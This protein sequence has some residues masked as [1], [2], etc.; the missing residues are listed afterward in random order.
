MKSEYLSII[1][2]PLLSHESRCHAK[3]SSLYA[4]LEL[5]LLEWPCAPSRASRSRKNLP[6]SV[7]TAL[8]SAALN[9]VVL[10]F[11]PTMRELLCRLIVKIGVAHINLRAPEPISSVCLSI[12]RPIHDSSEIGKLK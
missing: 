2:R 4:R 11:V 3:N 12:S 1:V 9:R 8:C 6:N 10:K 5:P 7:T